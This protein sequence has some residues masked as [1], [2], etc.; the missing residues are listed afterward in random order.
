MIRPRRELPAVWTTLIPTE[1]I[2]PSAI[3]PLERDVVFHHPIIEEGDFIPGEK[4][5]ARLRTI[6]GVGSGCSQFSIAGLA[7]IKQRIGASRLVVLDLRE[8]SHYLDRAGE[9]QHA[10]GFKNWG[11]VGRTAQEIALD[12]VVRADRA[13]GITEAEA[14]RRAGV[15]YKRIPITDHVKPRNEHVDRIVEL[16]EQLHADD[17]LL[18]HCLAGKGRTTT[19]LAMIDILRNGDRMS[20]QEIVARQ[21]AAG[22]IDLLADPSEGHYT[23]SLVRDRSDLLHRFYDYA[24]YW[25]STAPELRLTFSRWL[26]RPR[27]RAPV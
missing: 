18:V 10:H 26:S 16:V 19:V 12:E 3:V 17:H 25:R 4:D 9:P 7:E 22:G 11:N 15:E 14:C 2:A 13:G 24:K 1:P 8:E 6:P 21:H 23:R 20:L 27:R 5:F